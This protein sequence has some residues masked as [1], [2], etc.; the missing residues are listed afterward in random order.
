MKLLYQ[1]G[2]K[3]TPFNLEVEEVAYNVKDKMTYTKDV[4]N[5]IIEVGAVVEEIVYPIDGASFTNTNLTSTTLNGATSTTGTVT[6]NGATNYLRGALIVPEGYRNIGIFGT[7]VSTKTQH[8][9]SMGTSYKC[10]A[11][12][13]TLGNL[14][15][16]A[17]DYNA[18]SVGH[19][20]HSVQ[21]G[22]IKAS[23]GTHI[24]T[25]G[26]V[27][28]YS[29]LRVKEKLEIIPN[30]LDK[31]SKINGYTYNRTDVV[32]D[33]IEPEYDSLHNPNKRFVGL[34]AQ[35]LLKVLPEAVLGGPTTQ[36]GTEDEHYSVAY[37]NVTALLIE[38]M[39]E[40]Q[41]QIEAMKIEIQRLKDK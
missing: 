28:A 17:Y 14:Y 18:N 27:T 19:G 11:D 4:W 23:I 5:K 10:A 29:D 35:E 7:Y 26:N 2:E 8:I 36:E 13:S 6:V 40:Q 9:W 25:S 1:V 22:I 32:P 34:V 15:G 12:G 16:I 24:W 3:P 20:F 39:K 21:N 31:I 33:E 37:G 41:A 30:A 38:G